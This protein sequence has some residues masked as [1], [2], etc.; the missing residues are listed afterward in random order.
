[1]ISKEKWGELKSDWQRYG[2]EY[3]AVGGVLFILFILVWFSVY[4][5]VM[6]DNHKNELLNLK[7]ELL[8]KIKNNSVELSFLNETEAKKAKSNLEEISK[9]DNIHFKDIKLSRKGEKF[10]IK[11]QF[12][13]AN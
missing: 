5:P 6:D 12:K 8:Q 4:K 3:L 10:E 13:S 2:K 11:V 9:K 7:T 1:M